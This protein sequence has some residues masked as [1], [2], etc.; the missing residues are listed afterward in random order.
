MLDTMRA[1]LLHFVHTSGTVERPHLFPVRKRAS[2]ALAPPVHCA[3][4]ALLFLLATPHHQ[5]RVHDLRGSGDF[6]VKVRSRIHAGGFV[7]EVLAYDLKL[8]APHDEK[9]QCEFHY[10]LAASSILKS[11]VDYS[12]ASARKL[13]NSAH[14]I[15]FRYRVQPGNGPQFVIG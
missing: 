8:A 5:R 13:S 4:G 1:L 6:A 11:S 12:I 9:Y 7:S 10:A 3:S 14:F 2:I 15:E